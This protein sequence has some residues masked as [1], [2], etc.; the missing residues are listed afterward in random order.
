MTHVASVADDL[1]YRPRRRERRDVSHRFRRGPRLWT[2]K[3]F[4]VLVIAVAGLLVF[5]LRSEPPRSHPR[6]RTA[7]PH[8]PAPAP[9]LA[10]PAAEAAPAAPAVEAAPAFRIQVASFLEARN[11]AR[12]AEELRAEGLS[13]ET[14]IIEGRRVRYRVLAPSGDGEDVEEL[15]ARLRDLGFSPRVTSDAVAVT[16]FVS[17]PDADDAAGRLEDEGIAVRVE[18]EDRAVSFHVVRV[19]AYPTAEAADRG[20]VELAARGLDGLVVRVQPDDGAI[21]P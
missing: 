12:M 3:P 17:T 20:R 16:G 1:E 8:T 13:V 7:A 19:G 5:A 2:R 10:T 9:A 14:R 21:D 15:L 4:L 18:E 6:V 11:A